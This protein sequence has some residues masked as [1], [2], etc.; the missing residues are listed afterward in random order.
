MKLI[1]LERLVCIDRRD[2]LFEPIYTFKG[3][4]GSKVILRPT[5]KQLRTLSQFPIK[6]I[7][8]K[9]MYLLRLKGLQI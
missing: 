7:L 8:G 4:M 2:D 1:P 5:F 3:S 6:Q 9:P